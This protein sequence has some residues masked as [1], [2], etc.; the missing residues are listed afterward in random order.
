MIAVIATQKPR[1][2]HDVYSEIRDKLNSTY[3][4]LPDWTKKDEL[5][6]RQDLKKVDYI[7]STWG[8]FVL[9]KDEI[10]TYLPN[11]KAVFYAAG[12]VQ[13]FARPFLELGIKV[14]SAWQANGV[15]VSEIAFSQI[16]LANK[17]FYQRRVKKPS[18]WNNSDDEIIYPGNYKTNVGILGAGSIGKKVINLLKNTD[19]NV[20]VYDP[21]LSNEKANEMGVT[22][23]DNIVDIFKTCHV[24]SNHI[25]NNEHTK[26]I[27]NSECFDNMSPNAVFINTGR[28]AQ[29]NKQA[30]IK[31]L[32]DC[33]N[34]L[35]IIDVLD[36]NEPP[37]E[38]EELLLLD[39]CF[40]SP[41]IAGSIGHEVK[42]MAKYMYSESLAFSNNEKTK[43]EVNL[44]MLS[45]MA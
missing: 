37:K 7:F 3:T 10:Q 9:T 38:D 36:P 44:N 42:R 26:G 34:R 20:Y 12:T 8:M 15:P 27:I 31:A 30:L 19:L 5:F 11:L 35:A 18:D 33:P 21:F 29:I 6:D 16:I 43:Y 45:T 23:L 24:I 14:F 4:F 13:S 1:N 25:A 28:C 40:I 22:K 17:G 2:I 41:H 32:K 39:N